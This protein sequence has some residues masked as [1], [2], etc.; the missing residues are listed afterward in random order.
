[1]WPSDATW[2]HRYGS[3]LAQ[4]MAWCHQAPS[5]YLSQRWFLIKCVVWHSPKNNLTLSIQ[6]TILCNEFNHCTFKITATSPRDQWVNQ[7]LAFRSSVCP[8]QSSNLLW[9]VKLKWAVMTGIPEQ[10]HWGHT[11]INGI[12]EILLWYWGDTT[13]NG[14]YELL[15]W[16]WGHTTIKGIYELLLW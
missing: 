3:T 11:A 13:I 10:Q 2:W 8:G 9:A 4:V 1:M 7:G 6:D 16:Y 5:H 15:L 12:Y 14:I